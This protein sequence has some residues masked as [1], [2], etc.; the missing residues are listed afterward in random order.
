MSGHIKRI[1][2]ETPKDTAPTTTTTIEVITDMDK[3]IFFSV[4]EAKKRTN[5]VKKKLL[6]SQM[7]SVYTKI[8]DAINKG[9]YVLKDVPLT[10]DQAD[11]LRLKNFYIYNSYNNCL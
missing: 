4:S 3:N 9:E 6:E 7:L 10:K 5:A 11:F 2:E 8:V 1:G